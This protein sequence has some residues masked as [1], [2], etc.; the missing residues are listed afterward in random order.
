M[1]TNAVLSAQ[2][3][4]QTQRNLKKLFEEGAVI[5]YFRSMED[6]QRRFD[7]YEEKQAAEFNKRI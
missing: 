6:L 7:R 3:Q 2:Q 4:D 5:E 1:D